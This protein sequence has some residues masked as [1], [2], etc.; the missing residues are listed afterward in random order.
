MGDA[1]HGESLQ[2]LG[3]LWRALTKVRG[4]LLP[5]SPDKLVESPDNIVAFVE[6]VN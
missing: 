1:E 6:N 3:K 4:N 5:D 2:L